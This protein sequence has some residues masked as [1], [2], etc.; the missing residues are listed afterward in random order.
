MAGA[1]AVEWAQ[2]QQEAPVYARP[3]V[4]AKVLFKAKA[5]E[6]L[7][8]RKRGLEFSRVQ[9]KR[10]GKWKS[11]Y[12]LNEDLFK[13]PEAPSKI[14]GDWGVGGGFLYTQ[15]QHKG[16]SFE[17]ED[18]VQYTT[19]AYSS[20][21]MSPFFVIQYLQ[22]DFWRVFATYRMTDYTSKARTNVSGSQERKVELQHK[23][24]S[25]IVQ[26]L[27]TPFAADVFYF[28]G[29]VEM[30]KSMSADLKLG[31]NKVPV[32]TEDLPT[33]FGGQGVVGGQFQFASWLSAFVEVRGLVYLNQSPT[34]MGAEAA[35]GLLIWP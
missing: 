14:S 5:G 12:L 20:T 34:V 7:A 15:L 3:S 30:S 17:T 32:A 31:G 27:W 21:S 6:K 18:Q 1:A 35:A 23:M 25:V 19:D 24:F 33:Y 26:R 8:I 28:G 2:L 10:D 11:G 9:V 29:G 16:K 4:D 13:E 22:R